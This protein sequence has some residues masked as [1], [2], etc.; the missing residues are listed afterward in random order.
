MFSRNWI[1]ITFKR[2][3]NDPG[4]APTEFGTF[5][6]CVLPVVEAGRADL[7]DGPHRL[8]EFIEIVPAPAAIHRDISSSSSN[9]AATAP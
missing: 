8:D 9:S 1:L 5:R 7:V 3:D 4:T 6:E 2:L